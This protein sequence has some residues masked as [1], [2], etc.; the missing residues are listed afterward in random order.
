MPHGSRVATQSPQFPVARPPAL[1]CASLLAPGSLADKLARQGLG[2]GAC[3]LSQGPPVLS[4]QRRGRRAS[5]QA[6]SAVCCVQGLRPDMGA[7]PCPALP[8]ALG[9]N[10]QTLGRGAAPPLKFILKKTR[11][12]TVRLLGERSHGWVYRRRSRGASTRTCENSWLSWTEDRAQDSVPDVL[13]E[14]CR[15]RGCVTALFFFLFFIVK[16]T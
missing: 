1:P 10:P 11:V 15:K 8:G 9:S 5:I 13:H 2:R 4:A 7:S 3:R 16:D 12:H 14:N 6:G